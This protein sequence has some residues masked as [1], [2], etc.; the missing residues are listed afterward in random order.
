MGIPD[1]LK[2]TKVQGF[3]VF[4]IIITTGLFANKLDATSFIAGMT[5]LFG[6]FSSANVMQKKVFNGH[7]DNR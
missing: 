7:Q 2:S 6:I 1:K 4:A 5:I 3:W